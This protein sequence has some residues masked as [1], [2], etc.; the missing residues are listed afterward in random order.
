MDHVASR[1]YD[2]YALDLRGMG[3]SDHPADY[4]A[5]DIL[6][7][8]QDAMAVARHIV[9]NT[10][11]APVVVGWSQGGGDHGTSSCVSLATRSRCVGFLS[12]PGN[13]FFVPPQFVHCCRVWSPAAQIDIC[14][15]QISYTP[16]C[17]V[18]I[19][20]R[21]SRLSGLTRLPP[22]WPCEDR[23]TRPSITLSPT[24]AT[25]NRTDV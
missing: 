10:G 17:L 4:S 8:V 13:G 15:R 18:L 24:P 5:I 1:G 25:S 6:S 22:S 16:S 12:V 20:S 14:Q 3:S 2:V 9:A 19:L 7:R 23:L 11:V 21:A